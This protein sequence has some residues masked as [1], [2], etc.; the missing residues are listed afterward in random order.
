MQHSS[1]QLTTRKAATA[2]PKYMSWNGIGEK[3]AEDW[4]I[5]LCDFKGKSTWC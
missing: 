1:L 5:E 2:L 4:V 3:D